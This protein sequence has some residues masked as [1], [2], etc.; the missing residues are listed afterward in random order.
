[1]KFCAF[2]Y[3]FCLCGI[4]SV[5]DLANAAS[6]VQPVYRDHPLAPEMI[7]L[8]PVHGRVIG[9]G[10]TEV[11][12]AQW[13]HCV[14]ARACRQIDDDHHWGRGNHPVINVSWVDAGQYTKWLSQIT[15]KSYRLPTAVEWEFAA[16]AGS[17]TAY[18]WGDKMKPGMARCRSCNPG[19]KDHGTMPVASYPPNPF[20]VYDMNGNLWEWIAD[21]AEK[22]PSE[23]SCPKR[24]TR[25][26]A[27]YYFSR[28][29]MATAEAPRPQTERSF[30]VGFRVVS[31]RN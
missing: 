16:R 26:G 23:A 28:Q 17:T 7:E 25:G 19:V 11:T 18:W 20:G 22:S 15:G 13:D 12:F 10:K 31:E 27:W 4:G 2:F 14:A 30:T 3:A 24:M 5:S 21:C 1:M 29:S 9:I 8:P 6:V